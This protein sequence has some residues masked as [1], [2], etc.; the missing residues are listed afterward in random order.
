MSLDNDRAAI[1]VMVSRRR[2]FV[3]TRICVTSCGFGGTKQIL[4]RAPIWARVF[5]DGGGGRSKALLKF[6]LFTYLVITV[7]TPS[8]IC[9]WK[10][11][12]EE[13]RRLEAK[14]VLTLQRARR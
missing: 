13:A 4:F 8:L 5:D 14:M 1:S 9:E 11:T 12:R 7:F 3:L 6:N 10:M 2:Y